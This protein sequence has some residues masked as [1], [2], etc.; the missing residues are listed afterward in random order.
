[1][2]AEWL[3]YCPSRKGELLIWGPWHIMIISNETMR[4]FKRGVVE[5]SKDFQTRKRELIIGGSDRCCSK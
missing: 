4:T 2:V 3:Q 1:M 5:Y